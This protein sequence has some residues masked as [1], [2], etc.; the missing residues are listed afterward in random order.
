[1]R[2]LIE[3]METGTMRVLA[4]VFSWSICR[5]RIEALIVQAHI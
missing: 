1:M 4:N 5:R 3:L 2:A